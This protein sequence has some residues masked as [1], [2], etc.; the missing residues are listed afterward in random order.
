MSNLSEKARKMLARWRKTRLGR[1]FEGT[2]SMSPGEVA[3]WYQNL[4]PEERKRFLDDLEH[5]QTYERHT[6]ESKK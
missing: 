2:T 1:L 5:K 3:Y 4:P 6:K